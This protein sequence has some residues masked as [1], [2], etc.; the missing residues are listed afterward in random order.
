LTDGTRPTISQEQK[1]WGNQI[2][3]KSDKQRRGIKEAQN[4]KQEE[5]GE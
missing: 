2:K 4:T 5:E 1:K 3:E